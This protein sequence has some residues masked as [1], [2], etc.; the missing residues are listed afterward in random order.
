MNQKKYKEYYSGFEDDGYKV[1]IKEVIKLE[2]NVKK[3][4]EKYPQLED[5]RYKYS[6]LVAKIVER[7]KGRLG[8]NYDHLGDI[9]RH[10][11]E[12]GQKGLHDPKTGLTV[13][14]RNKQDIENLLELARYT[15]EPERRFSLVV[16]ALGST[17]I[18]GSEVSISLFDELFK[19]ESLFSKLT[20]SRKKDATSWTGLLGRLRGDYGALRRK[21]INPFEKIDTQ[22]LLRNLEKMLQGRD[23]SESSIV[24]KILEQLYPHFK[25]DTQKCSQELQKQRQRNMQNEEDV[26]NHLVN[27]A[28]HGDFY[29]SDIQELIDLKAEE[30]AINKLKK[31]V[32]DGT[33]EEKLRSRAINLLREFGSQLALKALQEAFPEVTDL[34]D[35]KH[36]LY[37]LG[38]MK[39]SSAVPMLKEVL[40]DESSGC[41]LEAAVALALLGDSSAVDVLKEFLKDNDDSKRRSA[42]HHL[43]GMYRSE[44][45]DPSIIPD[46]I[47]MLKEDESVK[48][49]DSVVDALA[50][51]GVV[52]AIEDLKAILGDKTEDTS[53]RS[54]VAKA[55]GNIGSSSTE[56]YVAID[57]AVST[58]ERVFLDKSEK[59][60][61]QKQAEIALVRIGSTRTLR[62]LEEQLFKGKD[63]VESLQDYAEPALVM[64]IFKKVLNTPTVSKKIKEK[65]RIALAQLG[66]EDSIRILIDEFHKEEE[67]YSRQDKG[68]E[69][70]RALWRIE[71]KSYLPFLIEILSDEKQKEVHSGA[72]EALGNIKD[73]SV[74]PLL[75]EIV[76]KEDAEPRA[77]SE[78]VISLMKIGT[79][80][81]IEIVKQLLVES[82]F[83]N[84][85]YSAARH[86]DEEEYPNVIP[87]L[88]E[89]LKDED[90][91]VRQAA[92]QSLAGLGDESALYKIRDPVPSSD[93][94]IFDIYDFSSWVEEEVEYINLADR[95]GILN[96]A[97][98]KEIAEPFSQIGDYTYHEMYAEGIT[99]VL[100]TIRNVPGSDSAKRKE[101]AYVF[102][103]EI[104][105]GSHFRADENI[106]ILEWLLAHMGDELKRKDEF[107]ATLEDKIIA[108]N[109]D[110]EDY[111]EYRGNIRK[112]LR[113]FSS[114]PEVGEKGVKL[115]LRLLSQSKFRV[116]TNETLIEWLQEN[117]NEEAGN[118]QEIWREFRTRAVKDIVRIKDGE[119][120]KKGVTEIL[121]IFEQYPQQK[122]TTGAGLC[123]DLLLRSKFGFEENQFLVE[124]VGE[125]AKEN[126]QGVKREMVIQLNQ[127]ARDFEAHYQMKPILPCLSGKNWLTSLVEKELI[128]DF[129]SKY[130]LNEE[131]K[132]QAVGYMIRINNRLGK[133]MS[134]IPETQI[135]SKEVPTATWTAGE[136]AQETLG[137]MI[138]KPIDWIIFLGLMA[139]WIVALKT[140][141]EYR[142][143]RKETKEIAEEVLTEIV[144]SAKEDEVASDVF[145]E[146]IGDRFIDKLRTDVDMLEN[147]RLEEFLEKF[148]EASDNERKLFTLLLLGFGREDVLLSSENLLRT[149]V[150]NTPVG[151]F[152][153]YGRAIRGK[154]KTKQMLERQEL[155][156]EAKERLEDSHLMADNMPVALFF[157]TL[158]DL[159]SG[160]ED[161]SEQERG[162]PG[163]ARTW[164]GGNPAVEALGKKFEEALKKM[165][166]DRGGEFKEHKRY[167]A[168]DDIRDLDWKVLGKTDKLYIKQK[169]SKESIPVIIGVDVSTSMTV[170]RDKLKKTAEA[171]Y[172]LGEVAKANGNEV[173]YVLFSDDVVRYFPAKGSGA[174]LPALQEILNMP[175]EGAGKT[176]ITKLLAYLSGIRRDALGKR[177]FCLVSD[178]A[179]SGFEQDLKAFVANNKTL[180]INVASEGEVMGNLQRVFDNERDVA[181][182]EMFRGKYVTV[183]PEDKADQSINQLL[184]GS[185]PAR[186]RLSNGSQRTMINNSSNTLTQGDSAM[187]SDVGGIDFNPA[188]LNLQIKRDGKGV[189]LP[190]HQQDI[191]N[192]QI[193]GL[194]PVII[195]ITPAT[196]QHLP[197]L[198]RESEEESEGQLSYLR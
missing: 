33:Q 99:K 146:K 111:F 150:H 183:R 151:M 187:M 63:V 27:E 96:N 108:E 125:N 156:Q 170:D 78:C 18:R 175:K 38:C 171:A 84:V 177:V 20:F 172:L 1:A 3:L 196:Y 162:L 141:A 86:L 32:L 166:P 90:F 53:L 116:D 155:W 103:S 85:R 136:L 44:I 66:D 154:E 148:E 109:K 81:A 167:V 107:W 129:T 134:L 65:A 180:G 160:I 133:I 158:V 56:G 142:S 190:V 45:K 64:P 188:H 197:F 61:L 79:P 16:L 7:L 194:T 112:I 173:G 36:I 87:F 8:F 55:L 24:V 102:A 131:S 191:E 49:R 6:A 189:P 22:T 92:A 89:A 73:P 161:E 43:S 152:K 186:S 88:R 135:T 72:V 19:P 2:G 13:L 149:I 95:V 94:D 157:D 82:K 179:D 123:I 75:V 25:G 83:S 77:R 115:C 126:P 104:L 168:G 46:L 17:V 58:L 5:G 60:R 119:E 101:M 9:T 178:F 39:D 62:I 118:D 182:K 159:F 130:V 76:T 40:V 23:I 37:A 70:R 93:R 164:Q 110:M 14:P 11:I 124:W 29:M 128:S 34:G 97:V 68:S 122:S 195:N 41:R 144:N 165:S 127:I 54:S 181:R 113:V 138:R 100:D 145:W 106:F 185:S 153:K 15:E 52:S 28:L 91:D 47:R 184:G 30:R 80:E 10:I 69:V 67:E 121:K 193:E 57:S 26:I 35:R 163:W 140:E 74:I 176:S 50:Y 198:S 71:D 21:F 4:L 31:V 12:E 169:E 105:Q 143:V 117:I 132:R 42:V 114:Y 147:K 137:Q 59:P 98:L 174:T 139:S 120:Y 192:I 48:V 51:L